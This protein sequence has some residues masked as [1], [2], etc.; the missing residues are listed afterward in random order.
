M[1]FDMPSDQEVEFVY[2]NDQTLTEHAQALLD[3]DPAE[4]DYTTADPADITD[5]DQALKILKYLKTQDKGTSEEIYY[6]CLMSQFD[7]EEEDP[8]QL[9][10][11]EKKLVAGSFQNFV[12][13]MFLVEYGFKFKNNWHHDY[14]C[15]TLEDLF[16]G[17]LDCPRIIINIPPRY[18]KTQILIYFVAWTMGHSPDSEYIMIGY[19][20]MLSEESSFKVRECIQN[21]KYQSIFSVALDTSSKAKDNF[22]TKSNGKVYATSTGGT[23]TGKGAGKLRKSW[24]GCIIADDPNNTLDA[25]SEINRNSANQWFANTLLSRRNNMEETPI[26]VIQQRVHENDVSGFLIPTE[27]QPLGGVGEDFTHIEIPAILT[28]EQLEQFNVPADSETRTAGDPEKDEYPLWNYKISLE[29]LRN[30][31]D[32]LPVLTFFGQYMQ[33]PFAQDGSIIKTSWITSRPTPK[34]SEI[35]YP[36]LVLDTAQTTS[37]RADYSVILVAYVLIDGSVFIEHIHRERME[38]PDLAE[39]VMQLFGKYKPRKIYVEYKSSGI[40]LIQYLKTETIPLPIEPIPRNASGGD[41]DSITRASGVSSYIKCGYVSVKEGADWVNT[42]FHEIMAFP[43]GTHDDQVDTLVD[44][45][46]KEVVAGGD[47]MAPMD[48]SLLPLKDKT[49]SEVL[50]KEAGEPTL[51]DQLLDEGINF[52]GK[53]KEDNGERDWMNGLLSG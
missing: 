23:L 26:I 19:A 2:E 9:T 15:N 37:K 11:D 32:N 51:F 50:E 34:A 5:A 17:R 20:K 24:G 8:T 10:L 3:L 41:G 14:L 27:D 44:L 7:I 13:Y 18:S 35:K 38:A 22:K 49:Y 33:R 36:V 46:V 42:F 6:N 39:T 25:Y 30:M 29:K 43:T 40:S 21:E 4:I 28:L 12:K 16:L 1:D 48:V 52:R 45:V 31:R 53:Q 47:Y